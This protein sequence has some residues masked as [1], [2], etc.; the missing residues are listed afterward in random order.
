MSRRWRRELRSLGGWAP[1]GFVASFA[2]ATVLFLPGSLFGLAGGALFGPVWGT[3]WNLAGATL[4]A[5]FAFLVARYVASDWVAR[6]AAGRLK[7]LIEGVE[8]EGW[9]FVALTRLVPLVPF[10]LLNYALGL[11]RIGFTSYV[12]ATLACMAPGAAGYAW[13]GYA[14]REAAAGNAGAEL[15]SARSGTA[16]ARDLPATPDTQVAQRA[17]GVDLDCR[18]EAPARCGRRLSVVDVRGPEEFGGP[19]GHIPGARNLPLNDLASARGRARPGGR[20][21]DRSRLQ[22]RQALRHG[23]RRPAQRAAFATSCVLR[24]GMEQWQRDASHRTDSGPS[25]CPDEDAVHAERSRLTAPSAAITP[26]GWPARSPS[27][28]A[29]RCASSC[30]GDAAACAKRSQKVPQ[31]Y[32]NVE[33]MLGAVARRGGRSACAAHAWMRAASPADDL[34]EGTRRGTMDELADWT[35]WADRVLAAAAL[36]ARA[37]LSSSVLAMTLGALVG[38]HLAPDRASRRSRSPRSWSARR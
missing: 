8:A 37:G 19:L 30:S 24:G 29:S 3:I 6:R 12:V 35:L 4:G 38:G 34:V 20:A 33:V 27:A 17:R 9:R 26:C 11:T 32:Y 15:R 13:L 28:R 14:G 18:A 7:Q 31:G 2:I 25:G 10:N 5:T 23:G 16:R 21:A 22:D 36:P 1:A